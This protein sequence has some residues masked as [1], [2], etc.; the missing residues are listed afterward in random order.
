MT[1]LDVRSSFDLPD[2]VAY[3]NCAYMGPVPLEA[4]EAGRLAVA[5]KGRPWTFAVEDFFEPVEELRGLLAGLL[6][7]DVEGVA[8]T[9]SV[10]YGLSVAANNLV[11]ARDAVVVVLEG[12][13]PSDVYCWRELARRSGGSVHT[14]AVPSD[15]DWTA[16]VLGD[17][18]RLG[19]R[20]GVVS[21]PPCH[22]SDGAPLDLVAVGVACRRVGAAFVVDSTQW[23]G[24]APF[25]V[26][27]VGADVVAGTTYKWL[28]GPYSLGF[29]WLAPHL[30][31]GVPL[32]HNWIGRAGSDDFAGLVNYAD[33]YRPGA[34]RY[35]MG[36]VS[37]FLL[38]PVAT[39]SLR[40][41]ASWGVEAISGHARLLTDRIAEGAAELGL[42]V[43]PPGGRS[44][45]LM[46][47]RLHGTGLDPSALAA[48]LARDEVF[49][50]VRGESVRVAAHAYNTVG[51]VDR[52]LASLATTRSGAAG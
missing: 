15:G 48:T 11:L 41:L 32:E 37:N 26:A 18:G 49:V 36:E 6:H 40:L 50:S 39:A 31:D 44:P 7:A 1:L 3:L 21:V 17:L 52:L 16:A 46:G 42:G 10:S 33:E 27:T 25:S 8:I 38:L 47:V 14:V 45:H 2:Q 20:A 9:P 30:R 4:I 28:V 43:A 12:Q 51:D 23:L 22:W 35:D 5:R 29:V 19:D 24:A 13:F 34:R